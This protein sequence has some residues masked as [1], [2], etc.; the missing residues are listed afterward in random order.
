MIKEEKTG[1]DSLKTTRLRKMEGILWS[2]EGST[3]LTDNGANELQRMTKT[4]I[5][6]RGKGSAM[7]RRLMMTKLF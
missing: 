3:T 2:V 6:V 5:P 7:E 1:N 4:Q